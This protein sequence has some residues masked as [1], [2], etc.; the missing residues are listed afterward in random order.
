[1]LYFNM[2]YIKFKYILYIIYYHLTKIQG[3]DNIIDTYRVGTKIELLFIFIHKTFFW[4]SYANING[5]SCVSKPPPIPHD[6][7]ATIAIVCTRSVWNNSIPKWQY[8][9]IINNFV[10]HAISVRGYL[11]FIIE[12]TLYI[13]ACFRF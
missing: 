11:M 4:Y 12:L 6:G 7:D 5:K 9:E 8:N 10:L 13:Q 3:W 1:M 2:I